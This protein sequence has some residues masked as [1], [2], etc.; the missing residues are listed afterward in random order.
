MTDNTHLPPPAAR[1][2]IPVVAI[3]ALI[4]ALLGG[5][6]SGFLWLERQNV[7]QDL[8]QRM[9]TMLKDIVSQRE[10]DIATLKKDLA[11]HQKKYTALQQETTGL[12]QQLQQETD[13]LKT[14][15]TTQDGIDKNIQ[16][17]IQ[18]LQTELQGVQG[19]LATFKSQLALQTGGEKIQKQDIRN[20][21]AHVENLQKD[22]ANI[23]LDIQKLKTELQ[24]TDNQAKQQLAQLEKNFSNLKDQQQQVINT[25]DNTRTLIEKGG[26]LNG[27]ALSE[28]EYLLSIADYKLKLERDV[29][30]AI[31]A[32]EHA[33]RRLAMIKEGPFVKVRGMLEANLA[34]LRETKLPDRVGLTQDLLGLEN[35]LKNLPLIGDVQLDELKNE[36]KP[37]LAG[38][39]VPTAKTE[40]GWWSQAFERVVKQFED[41]IVINQEGHNIPPLLAM[42]EE[43]FLLENLRL[44]LESMRL[45][46]LSNDQLSFTE[47]GKMATQWVKTYFNPKADSVQSFL[48]TLNRMDS[49]QLNPEL[50]DISD[51]VTTFRTLMEKRTPVQG[52]SE[53]LTT[54]KENRS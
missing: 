25:I 24:N 13:K 32:L 6:A 17:G 2:G 48:K 39:P 3:I 19:S 14:Y 45:A 29:P 26:D 38:E 8:E 5:G 31:N 37:N 22:T 11:D 42:E 36:V 35:Q 54:H 52:I 50:P 34:T 27:L 49:V 51:T 4:L 28:T 47:S 46:L 15:N 53:T 40:E 23:N 43:Y 41:I 7:K 21:L 9:N 20:M 44:Q 1:K 10:V 30:G 18:H 16:D 33:D 12:R